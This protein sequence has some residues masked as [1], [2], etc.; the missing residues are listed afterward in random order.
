[1]SIHGASLEHR[2]YVL[3]AVFTHAVIGFTL[4][5]GY[6][7]S[8]G[9]AGVLGAVVP[10][11]DL[12]FSPAWQSPFVHR[13][14]THTPFLGGVV[15]AALLVTGRRRV[16]L[17]VAIGFL[18]H[19]VLDSLTKSGVMWLYPLSV[20]HFAF[21]I[22]VHSLGPTLVI[23]TVVLAVVAVRWRRSAVA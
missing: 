2:V 6:S 10:D 7:R 16:A 9:W 1:M 17:G 18:S 8:V 14:L 20:H 21:D 13:G 3:R 15:V 19:L 11:I 23:W 5:Y 12:L 22:S 4:A